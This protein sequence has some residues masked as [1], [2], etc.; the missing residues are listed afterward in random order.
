MVIVREDQIGAYQAIMQG[1]IKYEDNNIEYV[2]NSDAGKRILTNP[3]TGSEFTERFTSQWKGQKNPFK[4]AFYWLKG[5]L[6]DLK[7]L[8]TALEGREAVVKQQS[9]TESKKRSDQ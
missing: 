8:K 3:T 1:L 4:D 5:E 6:L 7:G 2:S 9:S